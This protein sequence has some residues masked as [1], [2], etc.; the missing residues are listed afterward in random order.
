MKHCKKRRLWLLPVLI[1]L[2]LAVGAVFP[3]LTYK[4]VNDNTAL[5]PELAAMVKGEEETGVD[6]A[7]ILETNLSAWEERLRL[8]N[9]AEER[10]ILSTFD[11]RDGE[12]TRDLLGLI[13]EKADGGVKVQILVDGFSG[14]VRMT[15][16]SL[17]HAVSSHPNIEIRHYNPINLLEPWKTQGRMHDK[18]VIVDDIGY[19]L[20]GRNSFDYFIGTYDTKHG[21]RDREVLV[22]NTAH[23]TRDGTGS[24]LYQVENYFEGV[25]NLEV[26]KP[27]ADNVKLEEKKSVAEN[28]E[29][30]RNRINSIRKDNP[31]LFEKPDYENKTYETEGI[32]LVSNPTGI[33]GKEPEVFYQLTQLMMES[34]KETEL[35]TPYLV[36]NTYMQNRLREVKKAVPDMKIILNSVENGD[37]FF[38]SSDYMWRKKDLTELDIPLYEYDGGISTHGKS[39]TLGDDIAAVGS[40]N[41]DLRSTY[42]DTELMLVIKSEGLT[43]ELKGHFADI[44]GDCRKVVNATEYET[45]SHIEVAEIPGW[46]KIVMKITGIV[47]APFRFLI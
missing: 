20:G 40:Y 29:M 34:G 3:F 36:C 19:I 41:F 5:L 12:S 23:G 28:R 26:T 15:G 6:R 1:V 2:Y 42:L 46:K 47:M 25:W 24:S 17:F 32:C 35:H 11:M 21:S 14:L 9:Q 16:R 33:Y 4:K 43:K 27:F 10:I 18:Y 7:M 38:A 30:L 44:R 37:N 45:P 8:I 31:E 13:L 39:F 22:Y